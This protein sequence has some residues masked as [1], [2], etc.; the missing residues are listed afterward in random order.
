MRDVNH[1]TIL[2]RL[3][4]LFPVWC[5]CGVKYSEWS[6]TCKPPY[7]RLPES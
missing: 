6:E 1:Q 2:S 3:S 4:V 7:N 5:S